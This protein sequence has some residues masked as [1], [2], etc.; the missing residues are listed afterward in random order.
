M[1]KLLACFHLLTLCGC[2]IVAKVTIKL[3]INTVKFYS[4]NAIPVLENNKHLQGR[5]LKEVVQIEL[6]F[7]QRQL[8][9]KSVCK[10][11]KVC[12]NQITN[13]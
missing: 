3:K 5:S 7:V 4:T 6:F 8:N 1:A 10:A 13:Q 12:T 2:T 9:P 11:R